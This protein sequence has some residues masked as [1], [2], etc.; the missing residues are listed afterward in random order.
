LPWAIVLGLSCTVLAQAPNPSRAGRPGAPQERGQAGL[1]G[2]PQPLGNNNLIDAKENLRRLDQL[3]GAWEAQSAKIKTLDAKFMRIDD[4]PVWDNK[5]TYVGRAILKSPDQAFLDF[6]RFK[7]G[8]LEPYEQTRCTGSE[9]YHY[10]SATNQ[11]FIY[12][13]PA[14]Q[15]QRALQEGPLPFLFNMRAAEAKAR[16]HMIYLGDDLKYHFLRIEPR[17]QIDREAFIRADVALR[18]EG[19]MPD[20]IRLHLPNQKDTQT[21]DFRGQGASIR[22]NEAVNEANFKGVV[23]QGWKVAHPDDQAQAQPR[24]GVRVRGGAGNPAAGAPGRRN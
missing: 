23:L 14:N 1:G 8:K 4:S 11:I 7:D 6:Q 9:V 16:Y 5:E 21:F 22:A 2:Q 17:E 3:L 19:F 15:R 13:M 18:K 24:A 20:W 12:T 10:R